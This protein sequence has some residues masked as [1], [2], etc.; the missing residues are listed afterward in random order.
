MSNKIE[1]DAPDHSSSEDSQKS[2]SQEF[3]ETLKKKYLELYI[4][5]R[6]DWPKRTTNS[7]EFFEWI[8]QNAPFSNEEKKI[9]FPSKV[10]D[11]GKDLPLT[12]E[13]KKQKM[14]WWKWK[15]DRQ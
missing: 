1:G 10:E 13:E 6:M 12:R 8:K 14:R 7:V 5:S 15:R 4:H 9:L 2:K 3:V 11:A